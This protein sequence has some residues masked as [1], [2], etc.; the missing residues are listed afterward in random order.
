MATSPMF[1]GLFIP[2]STSPTS[3]PKFAAGVAGEFHQIDLLGGFP[4]SWG[5]PHSWMVY[6]GKY[7]TKM[8]DA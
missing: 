4:Q 3:P 1:D 8:D 2:T 6:H 5:Y 7:H